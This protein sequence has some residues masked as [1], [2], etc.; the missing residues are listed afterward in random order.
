[1]PLRLARTGRSPAK[2]HG[3]EARA[4]HTA[5]TR[6]SRIVA[7]CVELGRPLE[8]EQDTIRTNRVRG[9]RRRKHE[10]Q[11]R[12]Y[13]AGYEPAQSENVG[14]H[15]LGL[16]NFYIRCDTETGRA[17]ISLRAP[18]AIPDKGNHPYTDQCQPLQHVHGEQTTARQTQQLTRIVSFKT[19]SLVLAM[20]MPVCV[21]LKRRV[22]VR[23][24]SAWYFWRVSPRTGEAQTWGQVA[25]AC[26]FLHSQQ[27]ELSRLV[28][29]P[30]VVRAPHTVQLLQLSLLGQQP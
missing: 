17:A 15:E 28:L 14:D 1:M 29:V 9:G 27:C 23:T 22:A 12:S 2:T 7:S 25:Q 21:D 11:Q 10:K 30:A 6:I 16:G 26:V 19:H 8:P 13:R 4:I 18:F 5:K 24:W 3:A 20:G